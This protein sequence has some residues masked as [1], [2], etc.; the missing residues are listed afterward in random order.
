M[1]I[2]DLSHTKET[3]NF[4]LYGANRKRIVISLPVEF[5][6][7]QGLKWVPNKTISSVQ[8]TSLM[9]GNEMNFIPCLQNASPNVCYQYFHSVYEKLAITKGIVPFTVYSNETNEEN[10]CCLIIYLLYRKGNY[11]LSIKGEK[12]W[13]I[14]T[15]VKETIN[16]INEKDPDVII[17]HRFQH[18][19]FF[20][21]VYRDPSIAL[22]RT[23][24]D[25]FYLFTKFG[26]VVEN[27][28]R[29]VACDT[30]EELVHLDEEIDFFNL[31]RTRCEMFKISPKEVHLRGA[32][33]QF[34]RYLKTRM[35]QQNI[36]WSAAPRSNVLRE[37]LTGG[38]IEPVTPGLY[39]KPVFMIDFK[40]MYATIIKE[41]RL[42]FSKLEFFP[43]IAEDLMEQRR[44]VTCKF[45]ERELKF[46]LSMIYG[47]FA[48]PH[49]EFY[50]HEIASKITT[51]GNLY[52]KTIIQIL[53]DLNCDIL[54]AH[55][56]SVFFS[57]PEGSIQPGENLK[58][59]GETMIQE[60]LYSCEL[61]KEHPSFKI[62][63]QGI[64]PKFVIIIPNQYVV[65]NEEL[66]K[67]T[68]HGKQP[69]FPYAD[70]IIDS[71]FRLLL[72]EPSD[73]IDLR[74]YIDKS[75]ENIVNVDIDELVMKRILGMDLS[76][77]K[78]N[79]HSD[80][81]KAARIIKEKE[82]RQVLKNEVI[83]YY[84][85]TQGV[86]PYK[87][88][89]LKID[90]SYYQSEMEHFFYGT[91]SFLSCCQKEKQHRFVKPLSSQKEK[92]V[93]KDNTTEYFKLTKKN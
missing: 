73:L 11:H 77:Y 64:S 90:Y 26:T 58:L 2:L 17:T 56:D 5:F 76:E 48:N 83:S 68:Y 81:V 22:G 47:T 31:L 34:I 3:T 57:L 65:V 46:F 51:T 86:S 35:Y 13:T 14:F 72:L 19:D 60:K 84:R 24:I 44:N 49:N 78:A 89:T 4:T 42:C 92:R 93:K 63:L 30:V 53:R 67:I 28:C 1:L 41:Y 61:M 71:F 38:Y 82:K 20:R 54:Y 39:T 23:V 91:L 36:V 33:F 62:A 43:K 9:Y 18:E 50:S 88:E 25:I 79:C 37:P 45:H 29:H 69:M 27:K 10:S 74:A 6:Q 55:T 32:S 15:D 66:T 70:R 75:I 8:Y 7:C 16:W 87:D 52:V 12:N 40:S 80:V 21:H 85:M 59:K